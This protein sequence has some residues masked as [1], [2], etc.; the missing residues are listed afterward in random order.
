MTFPTRTVVDFQWARQSTIELTPYI[1]TTGERRS[2]TTRFLP[3]ADQSVRRNSA[4]HGKYNIL[5]TLVFLLTT[6]LCQLIQGQTPGTLDTS[7]HGNGWVVSTFSS[8]DSL[9]GMTLQPD[10]KM[11]TIGQAEGQTGNGNFGFARFNP[12]GSLDR[13]FGDQ[14]RAT[15][16]TGS[17]GVGRAIALQADGRIV[18][19]GV[20]GSGSE[21]RFAGVRLN[22]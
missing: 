22:S 10:G 15:P 21:A 8:L 17:F 6:P 18:G 9:Y 1:K 14:G 4:M 5:L 7:F 16:M 12:D 3:G 20:S 2:A 13:T 11:V 19:A